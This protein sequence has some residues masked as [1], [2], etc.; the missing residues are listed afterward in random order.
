MPDIANIII[1]AVS[2][3]VASAVKVITSVYGDILILA[4]QFQ[5]HCLSNR[6]EADKLEQY[7][8]RDNLSIFGL[9]EENQETEDVLEVK[10]IKLASDMGMTLRSEV[11]SLAHRLEQACFG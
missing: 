7:Q 5:R 10:V 8:R 4:S 3:A 1:V 6:Y 11:I 2:T 9:D